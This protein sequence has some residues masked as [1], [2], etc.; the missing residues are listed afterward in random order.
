MSLLRIPGIRGAGSAPTPRRILVLGGTSFL[1]PAVVRA[2]VIAGHTVT[3]FNRG[4]TNPELFSFLEK[5]RGLRS[6]TPADE[7]WA[8]VESRRWDAVID[9]WPYDPSLAASA[10]R[11]LRDQAGHYLY[12]SSIAAYDRR[13]FAQPDLPEDAPLNPNDP[14]LRPYDRGKAESERR[15]ETLVGGKLTV[16]RPGPIK[17]DRDDSPDLLAWLRRSQ[18]GGRHIGPGTGDDHV[19][20]VDVKDVA[21]FL[22]LAIERSLYGTF[23]LTGAPMTFRQF[24]ERCNQA[25][26]SRAEFVWIPR[27]FLHQQDLDPAPFNSPT[28]P[29]YLGKFPFWHPEPERRGFFQIS[30]QKAFNVGWTQRPFAETAADYLW[31]FD[32][33]GPD[34]KWT[35]ELAP[36]V[37]ARVLERWISTG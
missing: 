3:L 17:G 33:L 16:V 31:S 9:V 32:T 35:D 24:V 5:L 10:A 8:A 4:I 12:V 22:V 6:S 34:F 27:D 23:N 15:L 11:R 21:Q 28:I 1:G 2:A 18:S 30:S 29:S 26:R 14:A 20:I 37:E 13:G 7:N 25:T 36:D 19:Q